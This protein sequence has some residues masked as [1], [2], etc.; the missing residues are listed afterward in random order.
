ML[1]LRPRTLITLMALTSVVACGYTSEGSGT[2]TLEATAFLRFTPTQEALTTGEVQLRY[3]GG[4]PVSGA[5]VTLTN[6]DND[7]VIATFEESEANGED[8]IYRGSF[9][10]YV[11]RLALNIA[12]SS[13]V[14]EATLEGPS[15]HVLAAPANGTVYGRT[16]IGDAVD[17]IWEA[18]D[19]LKADEVVVRFEE[20][21]FT[22]TFL[23][24]NDP[25]QVSVPAEKVDDGINTIS[26]VRRNRTNLAGGLGDSIFALEYEV[27]NTI[28]YNP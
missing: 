8:G 18:D 12:K 16:D 1:T 5:T 21:N 27:I 25:G 3:S 13:D 28:Q 20:S 15:K 10:G 26:V 23:N 2:Q 4:V 11:R 7:H 22:N 17:V 24:T 9:D 6:G 19:G 14:I